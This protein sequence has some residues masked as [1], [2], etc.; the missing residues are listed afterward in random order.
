MY[1]ILLN[2]TYNIIEYLQCNGYS[3][4]MHP[5]YYKGVQESHKQCVMISKEDDRIYVYT[6][7]IVGRNGSKSQSVKH[8]ELLI[9]NYINRQKNIK[10]ILN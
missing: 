10:N 8:L 2:N 5:K 6:T 4:K 3:H 7:H 1:D 9:N